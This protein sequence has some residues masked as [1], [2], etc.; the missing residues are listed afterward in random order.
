MLQVGIYDAL[1]KCHTTF[2][3][4][5]RLRMRGL[6][7]FQRK[8]EDISWQILTNRRRRLSGFLWR[9]RLLLMS[10]YAF[11]LAVRLKGNALDYSLG[12]KARSEQLRT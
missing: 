6:Y 12:R 1:H 2:P 4:D 10:F 8:S 11:L 9:R 7:T 5:S 3:D